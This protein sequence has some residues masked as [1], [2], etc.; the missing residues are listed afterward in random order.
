L[1][2]LLKFIFHQ[3]YH[4]F[5]WTYDFVAAFVSVGR[6]QDWRRTVLPHIRGSQVLEVGFGTGHLQVELLQR[7]LKTF[8]LDESPQMV[9]IAQKNILKNSLYP[10]L[11]LGYAQSLPFATNSFDSLVA[12]F[13]SEYIMDKLTLVELFRVLKFSGRL[14]I[15]PIAWIGGRSLPDRAARWLFRVTGQTAEEKTDLEHKIKST[16]GQ[17]GF[18]VQIT[19]EQLRDSLVMI[20]IAEKPTGSE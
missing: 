3:F 5:A 11:T 7:G 17:A 2:K 15:V 18:D 4:S 19:T 10:R 6:W 13:P 9:A 20:I 1:R 16:L 14:V 8:G 12:T